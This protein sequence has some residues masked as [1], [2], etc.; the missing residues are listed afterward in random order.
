MNKNEVSKRLQQYGLN[1]LVEEGKISRLKILLHQFTSPLIYIYP[2][3]QGR[4]GRKGAQ[5]DAHT[6][7]KGFKKRQ[8]ERDKQRGTR[9]RRYRTP[10]IWYQGAG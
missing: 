5:E 2:G 1:K 8:R 3:I 10:G 9:T 4:T 6:K 7:G